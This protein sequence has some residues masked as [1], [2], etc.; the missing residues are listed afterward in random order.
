MASLSKTHGFH[1]IPGS[2]TDLGLAADPET[3]FTLQVRIRHDLPV[4]FTWTVR[5]ANDLTDLTAG[6][7]TAV[8]VGS[9]TPD[10]D[11]DLY[12]FRFPTP[13]SAVP[14]NGFMDVSLTAP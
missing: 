7:G 1:D 13:T 2:S 5:A 12:L 4:G 10:G 3:Y 9:S 8:Q 14:G 6:A 11:F